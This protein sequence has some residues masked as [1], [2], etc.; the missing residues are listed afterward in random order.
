MSA[1]SI[2]IGAHF[3]LHSMRSA[4][5]LSLKMC[6]SNQG[7]LAI[8][9]QVWTQ[10][11]PCI[12]SIHTA[13]MITNSNSPARRSGM[14]ARSLAGNTAIVQIRTPFANSTLDDVAPY[15]RQWFPRNKGEDR[16]KPGLGERRR[17]SGSSFQ[18]F[19]RSRRAFSSFRL[20]W[21]LLRRLPLFSH[22]APLVSALRGLH[23]TDVPR[24]FSWQFS[25]AMMHCNRIEK[26]ARFD[27]LILGGRLRRDEEVE[28]VGPGPKRSS[29]FLGDRVLLIGSCPLGVRSWCNRLQER[30]SLKRL[31]DSSAPYPTL[32]N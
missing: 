23:A 3:S 2:S 26:L 20:V 12:S 18:L 5:S 19:S 13:I 21:Q 7:S 31:E 6:R 32:Q 1:L 15:V 16:A 28:G 11:D 17:A 24:C 22:S 14:Q 9:V 30:S 8:R 25:L 29:R 4:I 27:H 10:S